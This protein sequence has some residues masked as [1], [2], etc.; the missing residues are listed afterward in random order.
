MAEL[1]DEKHLQTYANVPRFVRIDRFLANSVFL[2]FPKT[3]PK[4]GLF[5]LLS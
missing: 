5:V 1:L 2:L 3:A 4:L